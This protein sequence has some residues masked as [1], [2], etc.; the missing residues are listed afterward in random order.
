M[1]DASKPLGFEG[2]EIEVG[3]IVEV[4][5]DSGRRVI[6]GRV[7]MLSRNKNGKWI[8][9]V[10]RVNES[11]GHSHPVSS[12]VRVEPSAVEARKWAII[13]LYEQCLDLDDQEFVRE[14]DRIV[15]EHYPLQGE[16]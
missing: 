15:H 13:D 5:D 16:E 14:F 1:Y 8:G 10:C 12:F 7:N 6:R 9:A 11:E 3:D 4:R 2:D